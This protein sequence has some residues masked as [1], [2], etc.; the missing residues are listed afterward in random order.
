MGNVKGIIHFSEPQDRNGVLSFQSDLDV[1]FLIQGYDRCLV[2]WVARDSTLTH[3]HCLYFLYQGK[4]LGIRA[5]GLPGSHL[6]RR[7]GRGYLRGRRR[8]MF[9]QKR[10]GKLVLV[11]FRSFRLNHQVSSAIVGGL[12]PV[13]GAT[14]R[15]SRQPSGS[16]PAPAETHSIQNELPQSGQMAG[17]RCSVCAASAT[18]DSRLSLAHP[19]RAQWLR[20]WMSCAEPPL[21][22]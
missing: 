6:K 22:A 18:N 15:A 19:S 4:L 9:S 12:V 1:K 21:V 13:S 16:A 20:F 2:F 7:A 10:A 3:F 5:R 11:V 8:E 17:C 14:A